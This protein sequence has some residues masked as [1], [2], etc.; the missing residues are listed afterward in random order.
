MTTIGSRSRVSL[1]SLSL[2]L[3]WLPACEGESNDDGLGGDE[4]SGD[5]DGDGDGDPTS[6]S[7]TIGKEPE[8]GDGDGDGGLL[9]CAALTTADACGDMLGCAPIYGNSL[10][11]DGPDSWCTSVE[12]EFIG[13]ASSDQLC[14]P[15]I[16]TLCADEGVWTTTGCVPDNLVPCEPPGEIT[17][18]CA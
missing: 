5:G 6:T 14:P 4:S 1:L 8:T 11:A 18:V 3:L 15:L 17:G 13:C 16:K 10:V 2:A 12:E 9:G 7:D